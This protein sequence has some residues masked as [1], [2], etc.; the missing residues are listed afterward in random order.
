MQLDLALFNAIHRFWGTSRALDAVGTFLANTLTYLMVIGMV[1]FIFYAAHSNRERIFVLAEMLLV[2][3]LSRF[4]ITGTIAVLVGRPRPFVTL[5]FEP[6]FM[7]L[8]S[9]AFPSG[10]V[11]ALFAISFIMFG[12]STPWGVVYLAL[13]LLVGIGRVFTGLHWPSDVLAAILIGLGSGFLIYKVMATPRAE[14][15]SGQ[16]A[17]LT[18]S[19]SADKVQ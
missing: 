3:I 8:T 4:L 9:G 17:A 14:L 2:F 16:D 19:S 11:S 10:H 18:N 6:P 1:V 5:G 13:S 7:P 12:Y 15:F